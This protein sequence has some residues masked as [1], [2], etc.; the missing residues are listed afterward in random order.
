MIAVGGGEAGREEEGDEEGQQEE[1]DPQD[2]G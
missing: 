1:R 2:A